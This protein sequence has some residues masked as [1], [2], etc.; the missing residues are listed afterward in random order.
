MVKGLGFSEP[1]GVTLEVNYW[2]GGYWEFRL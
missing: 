2:G 1:E